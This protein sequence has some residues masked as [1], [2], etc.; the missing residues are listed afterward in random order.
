MRYNKVLLKICFV[1][2]VLPLSVGCISTT[3]LGGSAGSMTKPDQPQLKETK[4]TKAEKI[5]LFDAFRLGPGDIFSIAV[6]NEPTLRGTY[7]VYP[8]CTIQFPLL[9]TIFVC[10]R[11]P[12][13]VREE[14]AKRLHKEFFQKRPSVIVQVKE[15]NSKKINVIGQVKNAGSYPYEPNTTILQA[16]ARA[17]GPNRKAN[18]NATRLI[19]K[20]GNSRKVY[21][22]R[23]D[24]LGKKKRS[25]VYL[26]PGDVIFVPESWL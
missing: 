18:L 17:G 24:P 2:C 15:Y 10:N 7:K 8:S 26:K 13:S 1:F 22:I 3:K 5:R 12:G 25:V 21:T 16:L 23:L 19:R 14:I 20:R 9:K 6:H 4:I 11:T